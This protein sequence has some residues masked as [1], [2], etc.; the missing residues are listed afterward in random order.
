MKKLL[1]TTAIAGVMVSGSAFA[2][3]TI[4]GELRLNYKAIGNVSPNSTSAIN[5]FGQEQQINVQTKGKLNVL[6]L[7]YAAG[8][9]LE[10]DGAQSTTLFN[11][12]T[13]M[14]FTNASSGTTISI[15]RD[16]VQRSDTDRS[17]AVLVGFSPNE[18]SA[19]G[20]T[21]NRTIFSQNIGPAVGQAVTASIIQATPIGRFS[22]SYAPT[23]NADQTTTSSSNPISQSS[24]A[25]A[26]NDEESAYEYGFTGDFG[27]KGLNT[28]YF[29]S[30]QK[31][32]AGVAAQTRDSEARSIGVA[33]NMGQFSVGYADKKYNFIKQS[34]GSG[35]TA[36]TADI[37]EKHYGVA[38][39]VNNTLSIG[40][41]Y[42][43][44]EYSGSPATQ[45]TK[46]I[47]IGYN[48]GPVA[49]T[50]GYA[51]NEDLGGVAGAENN[52]GMIRF[53]GAF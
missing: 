27:V 43:K 31:K 32:S 41:I 51:Q 39:A 50:V 9:S 45:T 30:H 35:S 52:Q 6:G 10:N 24:E 53:I 49:L 44:G 14:D 26:E 34:G 4:T 22:Y 48:L 36:N 40:A 17:A 5:G 7:D 1:L 8:F 33:Y 2:Q 29:K 25:T 13:Y 12:N 15:S 23:G 46:G 38:Y 11:E 20:S 19:D 47:N 3:T 28:Y 16:H 21:A 42:A 37:T 18:L